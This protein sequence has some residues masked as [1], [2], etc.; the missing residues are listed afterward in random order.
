MM[1]KKQLHELGIFQT[2]SVLIDSNY[3]G[4]GETGGEGIYTIDTL[5][6]DVGEAD[7][8]EVVMN[9][10]ECNRLLGKVTSTIAQNNELQG[11]EKTTGFN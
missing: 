7:G 10:K 1:A 11:V 4:T 9:V 8:L 2:I 5:L 6:L 3:N